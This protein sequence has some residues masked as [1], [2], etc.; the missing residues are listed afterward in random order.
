[1]R[2]TGRSVLYVHIVRAFTHVG[3]TFR[4]ATVVDDFCLIS[5]AAAKAT[6]TE[7]HLL[8]APHPSHL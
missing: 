2:R 5:K 4:S 1:M 8:H 6:F 3:R 7:S